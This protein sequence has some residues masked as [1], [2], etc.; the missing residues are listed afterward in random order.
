[1]SGSTVGC[2]ATASNDYYFTDL[3]GYS[4]MLEDMLRYHW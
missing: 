1:M 4:P 3:A 2:G